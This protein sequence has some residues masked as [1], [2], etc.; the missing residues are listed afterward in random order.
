LEPFL[1]VDA[2]FILVKDPL[3]ILSSGRVWWFV[4]W[5]RRGILLSRRGSRGGRSKGGRSRRGRS[6]GRRSREAFMENLLEFKK[7]AVVNSEEDEG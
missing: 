2:G 5:G 3:A 6:R 1:F 4:S 7:V